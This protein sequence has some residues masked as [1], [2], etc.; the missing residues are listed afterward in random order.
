MDIA[1]IYEKYLACEGRVTTDSRAVRG[2]ELFI[3]LKGE[4]FDGNRFVPQALEAGAA[5]AVASRDAG[6]GGDPRVIA[7]EDTYQALKALANH[8]RRQLSIPVIGLTGTNGKTTT[9]ELIRAA[10]SASFR[11]CATEGNLNNDIGVPL[12]LLKIRPE[13]EIAVIEMGANHPDDIEKLVSIV[14]PDAGLITNV[15]RAH[16][17]GFGSFEGVKRAKGQLYDYL[18]AHGGTVFLNEDNP[19]LREMAAARAGLSIVPYGVE[20]DGVQLLPADAENPFLALEYEGLKL[21]TSLVGAY[22]ADNVLAA[23]CIARHY[24]VPVPDAIAAIAAYVPSNNRSQ[25]VRTERNTLIV[26][27]YNANPSSMAAALR[28]FAQLQAP[29]KIALLGDMLELGEESRA[30]HARI[31]DML[32]AEGLD[33]RLVGAEFAAV[34]DG[35]FPTFASSEAL[36]EEF[37]AH[38]VS[39][40]TLLVKGSRGIAMEKVIPVL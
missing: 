36:A 21:Q 9:K 4:N 37:R 35:R 40:A 11:V 25:R 30:E 15:G 14:E 12:S 8:H 3:A 22:N 27:A 7:V 24:G 28:N 29:G 10:L 34:A 13:T 39:G 17:L 18:A 5:W 31:V 16:L 26:D 32:V 1:L 38:P 2:G 19:D 33:A 20:Y 6:L 23:L